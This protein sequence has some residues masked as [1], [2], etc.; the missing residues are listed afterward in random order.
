MSQ[1][2]LNEQ[3][4]EDWLLHPATK[5]LNAWLF[6][7]IEERKTAWAGGTFTDQSQYATAILNAKAI[8][9]C[10]AFTLVAEL[11]FSQLLGDLNDGEPVR[12]EASGPG[13]VG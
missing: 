3:E 7:Q 13:S 8:G 10:E 12:T 6:S 2:A 5:A 4:W 11:N 9:N 1:P